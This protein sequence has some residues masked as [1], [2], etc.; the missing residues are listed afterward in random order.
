M[1]KL[2]LITLIMM[3]PLLPVL[4]SCLDDNDEEERYFSVNTVKVPDE[5]NN[6]DFYFLQDDGT[7]MFPGNAQYLHNYEAKEGQRAF[8]IYTKLDE[9]VQ[10]YDSNIEVWNIVDIL[11]KDIVNLTPE[12]EEEIGDDAIN[13]PYMWVAQGYLTIEFQYYGTHREDKKHFLNLVIN[14]L[15]EETPAAAPPAEGENDDEYV[16]LEFR[17]NSEGDSPALLGEGYVSFKLDK[18]APKLEGKKGLK[19]RVKTLYDG[20]QVQTIDFDSP[21]SSTMN[22]R[23][24]L[25]STYHY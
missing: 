2:R 8:V 12:N 14:E 16:Y 23:N 4:H 24:S 22:E 1:K 19:I 5:T 6:K 15:P 21:T 18:I 20:V 10:G 13:V 17:H 11:T 7:K 3:L 25:I 9:P